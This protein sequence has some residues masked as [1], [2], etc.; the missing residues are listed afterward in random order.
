MSTQRILATG[1]RFPEGPIALPGGDILLVEIARGTLSRVTPAGEVSV[2]AETGGGPNG[3]A[4]GPD[5]KVYICNNGGFR[6][7]DIAGRLIPGLSGA[8]YEGGRIERVDIETGAVEV[9][10]SACDGEGLKGPN[11][12]VFDSDGGFWFTDHGKSRW[13]DRDRGGVF[14]ARADGSEIV[15]VVHPIEDPNGVG[16]SADE[17]FLYVA[18]THAGRLWRFEIE[19]PGRIVKGKGE[20]RW[21]HGTL[22]ASVDDFR[23][24]DSLAVDSAGNV[25]VGTILKGGITV[26]APEGGII[27]FV[28]TPGDDFATNICFGGPDLRTAYITLS[29]TGQLVEMEWPRPGLPLN[30][31]NR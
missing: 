1:L 21:F 25:C 14:Y 23:F 15:E 2:V 20:Q 10:Y 4:M 9:L 16:L 13:R 30:H 22:L 31:L 6:W 11:D 8:E 5:G 18:E 17:R 12:I 26:I 3:A 28:E 27:D 24:F 19:A 7:H 29:A